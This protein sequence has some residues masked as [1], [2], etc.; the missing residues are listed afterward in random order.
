MKDF[1]MKTFNE[2]SGPLAELKVIEFAAHGPAPFAAM[3][4][5]DMGADVIRIDRIPA[6][7]EL[8]HPDLL[9]RSR[10][11][12]AIDL[13]HEDGVLLVRRAVNGADAVI[14]GFRPGVMERLGIGPDVLLRD[15]PRLVYGR[16]TGWG[17]DG[18]YALSAGHDI[19]YIAATGA[20]HAIGPTGEPPL[21]PLNLVGD[22]GGGG[23]LLA[24]G[25]CAAII[26]SGSSGEGQVVDG[27]MLDGAAL[28]MSSIYDLRARGEWTE[29]RGDN[30]LDGGAP[31]YATY[32]T[33]DGRYIAIGATEPKFYAALLNRLGL[34]EDSRFVDW[35]DRA[36]W[37]RMREGF[38]E[39]FARR[40][41][42]DW[43]AVF[44]GIDAC[45]SPVLSIDEA[46]QDVHNRSR[47]VFVTVDGVVQPAPAPRFGRTPSRISGPPARPGEHTEEVLS[48]W[49][50]DESLLTSLR[51]RSVVV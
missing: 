8:A 14:E 50:V 20:L 3:M 29:Q 6:K 49:G 17:Q 4:L 12:V 11:S 37:P 23:M 28:L 40:T 24:L 46:P 18:P 34:A 21:P 35:H 47:G 26:E 9:A 43:S 31:F 7:G 36:A 10:R 22:F 16:A 32:E 45:F 25:I 30:L 38:S 44:A 51:N 39:I 5:A 42:D 2:R 13:K 15:N 33:S 27:A 41:R 48:E 19:N 1:P